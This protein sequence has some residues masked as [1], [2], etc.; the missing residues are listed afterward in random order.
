MLWLL[1][2]IPLKALKVYCMDFVP[3]TQHLE[4]EC[5]AVNLH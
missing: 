5:E 3:P 4:E 2:L 1:I